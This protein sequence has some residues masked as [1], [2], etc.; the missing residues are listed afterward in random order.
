MA[1]FLG[2]VLRIMDDF[3]NFLGN[4]L[5]IFWVLSGYIS[6]TFLELVGNFFGY[7]LGTFRV[8]IGNSG[9]SHWNF[10]GTFRVLSGHFLGTFRDLSWNLLLTFPEFISEFI[11][12]QSNGG[13]EE[14]LRSSLVHANR[15]REPHPDLPLLMVENIRATGRVRGINS[16]S[17]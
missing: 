10:T 13:A 8:L 9:N 2:I 5:G 17:N 7:I 6:G 3:G 16:I 12:D 1:T 15:V 11:F 14:S 4:I